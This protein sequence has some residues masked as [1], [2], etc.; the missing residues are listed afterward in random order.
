MKSTEKQEQ[1]IEKIVS[2]NLIRSIILKHCNIN[3]SITQQPKLIK[4]FSEFNQFKK[5]ITLRTIEKINKTYNKIHAQV[6]YF[7]KFSI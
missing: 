7:K 2:A 5:A 3:L 6:S 4:V 1:D